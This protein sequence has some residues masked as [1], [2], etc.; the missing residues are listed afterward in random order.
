MKTS[1]KLV[2]G[3]DL[4]KR[5][6]ELPAAVSKNVQRQALMKAGEPI[7][8]TAANLAPRDERSNAPHLADNIVI[9]KRSLTKAGDNETLVEVGPALQPSDH[10]YGFF[11]EFG[12]AT[13]SAQPFMRPAFDAEVGRSLNIVMAELWTSIR[14]RLGFGGGRSTTGGNL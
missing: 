13:Q 7:R 4:E 3:P 9:G 8:A 2:G 14:K 12:T 6:R 11:Q 1:F 5:L 10:F